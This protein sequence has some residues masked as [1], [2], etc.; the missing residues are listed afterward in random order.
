MSFVKSCITIVI[1]ASISL[2]VIAN[3]T[4]ERKV[5][6]ASY[7]YQDNDVHNKEFKDPDRCKLT[8]SSIKPESRV[9]WSWRSMGRKKP[10]EINFHFLEPEQF[11]KVRI[12][13]CIPKKFYS[14][15]NIA[16]YGIKDKKAIPFASQNFETLTR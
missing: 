1:L 6:P 16:I 7:D 8:D 14:I 4:Q 2:S 15:K 10:V 12:H 9:I 3:S 13:L 5:V 11:T